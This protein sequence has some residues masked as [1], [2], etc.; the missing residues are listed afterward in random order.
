MRIKD[1][2][3]E[4]R[5][6]E[7]FVRYGSSNLSDAELLAIILK[8]G[9]R[10]ENVVDM[11]NRLIKTYG[12]DKLS[13]LTLKELQ[14]IK[15]IGPAKA[16]Q[17]K[18]VFEINK[19]V[20]IRVNEGRQIKSAKDVYD[21]CYPIMCDLDREIFMIL[22]LDTKNRII[23]DEIISVGTLNSTIVHPREV[24]KNA[25]KDSVNSIII[26]H[27]HPSGD[28]TPSFEDDRITEKFFKAGELIDIKVL[29]H[30]I[31]GKDNYYSY[32]DR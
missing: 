15:G 6:R 24:F 22:Y 21:Y 11:C 17:I 31:I 5:P 4:N 14:K 9:N 1:I 3:K 7:R 32:K 25:I 26:I 28:S 19:R 12:I 27:N 23:K 20:N 2:A 30:V 29:D 8:T 16:M 13:T 18:A 10:G